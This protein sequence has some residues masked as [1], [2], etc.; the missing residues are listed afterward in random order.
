MK[1]DS[2]MMHFRPEER[3]F[4]ERMIDLAERVDDRQSPAL[5][6]FLDPRQQK[7]A[8]SVVRRH[9]DVEVR[10]LGGPHSAER[11]RALIAPSY[12]VPEDADFE[13]AFLRVDVPGEYVKLSHGDYLGALVGLGLKRGK[14]GDLSV[15]DDGCDLAV[16]RDMADFVRLHLT[17]VGRASVHVQE[18]AG[19]DYRSIQRE[20]Q[21]KEFTV[22]S[23]RLDAVASDAFNLSRTKVVDPIKSGKLQLNWQTIDNPATLVE[24]GDVISLRGHGR[25][26]ILE[27]GGQTKKGRTVLKVGKYI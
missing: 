22:M 4:V 13:L 20:F 19:T 5:T 18:I 2:I 7:I 1:Q 3:P 26:K 15:W 24:E 11:Q 21:E 6:D 17:Q 25:V 12:W 8:V 9:A 10:L 14:L 23:L 16:T 27:V